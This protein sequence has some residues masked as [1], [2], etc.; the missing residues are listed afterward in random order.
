MQRLNSLA[1]AANG[2]DGVASVIYD[3]PSCGEISVT[4]GARS[5]ADE[6]SDESLAKKFK[7][8]S[9]IIKDHANKM[10]SAAKMKCVQ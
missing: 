3:K 6:R 4:T 8:L 1:I 5:N 7:E 2:A 9:T 10:V